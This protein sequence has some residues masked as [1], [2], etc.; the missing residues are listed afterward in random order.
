[1]SPRTLDPC[2]ITVTNE[3]KKVKSKTVTP[4]KV[5][6]NAQGCTSSTTI[7]SRK[8][9]SNSG[10][11]HS[12]QQKG[13]LANR[14]DILANLQDSSVDRYAEELM[15]DSGVQPCRD[16]NVPIYTNYAQIP[17]RDTNN[18]KIQAHPTNITGGNKRSL[19]HKE[20]KNFV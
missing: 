4:S 18:A 19:P 7:P 15:F 14:F 5:S 16:I 8:L 11:S 10:A 2:I 13:F 17:S 9:V 20:Q 12:A 1:M 3:N 6:V